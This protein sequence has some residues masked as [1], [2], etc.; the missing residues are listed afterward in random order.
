ML[1]LVQL[2]PETV[3]RMQAHL[4]GLTDEKLNARF[5]IS[6]NTWRKIAAGQ[7]VRAS[8]AGRLMMRLSHLEMGERRSAHG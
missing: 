5:G 2:E 3:E 7:R 1:N 4:D 6:Y 8:V